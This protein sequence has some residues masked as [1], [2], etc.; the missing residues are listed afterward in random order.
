MATSRTNSRSAHPL[1]PDASTHFTLGLMAYHRSHYSAALAHFEAAV[2][3]EPHDHLIHLRLAFTLI[4]LEQP[5]RAL[6][7]L[8]E[9]LQLNPQH[10]P[11]Y[12]AICRVA[13]AEN[14]FDLAESILEG[15]LEQLPGNLELTEQLKEL[16]AQHREA[17]ETLDDFH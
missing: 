8:L 17:A 15:G 12:L 3:M 7:H 1:A 2:R 13:L 11:T 16:N 6:H 9:S 10:V 5:S 4:Q 14:R